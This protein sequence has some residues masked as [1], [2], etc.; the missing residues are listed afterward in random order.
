MARRRKIH[1]VGR[2]LKTKG[3]AIFFYA[4]QSKYIIPTKSSKSWKKVFTYLQSGSYQN[5]SRTAIY[6]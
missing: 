5:Q 3:G 2:E 1:M 6:N 4:I